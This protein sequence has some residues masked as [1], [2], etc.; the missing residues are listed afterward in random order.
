MQLLG[1]SKVKDLVPEMV[2]PLVT[3][4]QGQTRAYLSTG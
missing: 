2:S 3:Q 1:A 4:R